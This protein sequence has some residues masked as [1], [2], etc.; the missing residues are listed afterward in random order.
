MFE[1]FWDNYT[2]GILVE[3]TNKYLAMKESEQVRTSA[4]K[5]AWRRWKKVTSAEVRVFLGLLLYLG[6]RREVRV[7]R[8]WK[9]QR[10]GSTMVR[11]MSLK[12]FCQI[13]RLLHIFDPELQLSRAEWFQ[14]LEPLNHILPDRCQQYY[15]PAS[16]AIVDEMMIH[17]GGKSYHTYQMPSKP[18]TEGYKVFA[19]CDTGYTYNWLYA[20]RSELGGGF[21]GLEVIL[22][23]KY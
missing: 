12:H 18:I 4:G 6:T 7:W 14:K 16:N 8:Y 19:L 17:F 1:L 3:G 21:A 9:E 11:A 20:S 13:K 2:I 23:N 22:V 15:L 10:W 5:L